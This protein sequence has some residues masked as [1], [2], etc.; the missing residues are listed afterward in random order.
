MRIDPTGAYSSLANTNGVSQTERT[1]GKAAE[2]VNGAT[3]ESSFTPTSDL[4][5]LL[6]AVRQ[7][8]ETRAEIVE[9]A[10]KLIASGDLGGA[11]VAVETAQ[12]IADALER[13]A[14]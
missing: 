6:T 14:K 8:P 9:N 3:S 5:R 13:P 10:A 12:V 7:L 11:N 4:S 1:A 2:A